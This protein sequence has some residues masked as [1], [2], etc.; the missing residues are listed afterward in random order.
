[1]NLRSTLKKMSVDLLLF[2]PPETAFFMAWAHLGS[3]QK[4]P[5]MEKLKKD[6]KNVLIADYLLWV[7]TQFINFCLVPERHRVLFQSVVMVFWSTF[8]SFASHNSLDNLN[9]L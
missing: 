8:I 6:Y 5:V 3:D 9:F 1:M 2:A 7:P 4:E